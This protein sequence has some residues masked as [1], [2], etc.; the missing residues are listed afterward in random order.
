MNR[1][2]LALPGNHLSRFA[3]RRADTSTTV[4]SDASAADRLQWRSHPSV[5]TPLPEDV[6]TDPFEDV[7]LWRRGEE[8][9]ER[10]E[11]EEDRGLRRDGPLV[12]N[13]V[14]REREETSEEVKDGVCRENWDDASEKKKLSWRERVRHF[15]WTWFC[16]TMA[17]GGIA[18]VLYTGMYPLPSLFHHI[19]PFHNGGS[20]VVQ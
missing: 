15:T 16:M 11:E 3:V 1:P 4:D 5:V 20:S 2:A 13:G 7:G 6:L 18:N 10:K 14:E 9:E 17:T 8:V 12:D 19:Y